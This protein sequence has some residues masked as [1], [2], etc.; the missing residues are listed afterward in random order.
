MDANTGNIV[1]IDVDNP[2]GSL[3]LVDANTGRLVLIDLSSPSGKL[4][5]V[6]ANTGDIVEIDYDN[7]TAIF[8][9]CDP[10]TG[11]IIEVDL[12]NPLGNLYSQ[13]FNTGR[14]ILESLSS[15]K[16]IG[17]E[18]ISISRQQ[19][20]FPSTPILDDFSRTN[21]SDI[22]GSLSWIAGPF[23]LD[24]LGINNNHCGIIGGGYKNNIWNISYIDTE[25]YVT[26]LDNA[27]GDNEMAIGARFNSDVGGY[28]LYWK[29]NG[30][31]QTIGIWRYDNSVPTQIGTNISVN[32]ASGNKIGLSV[33]G[34]TLKAYIYQNGIWSN[35]ATETDT[36][37]S[38]G[39]L[40]LY[41]R[42]DNTI[43]AYDDFGG[44]GTIDTTNYL[45]DSETQ[46][47]TD[48]ELIQ[49]I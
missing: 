28:F 17:S 46:F 48:S 13:D 3:Y 36:T 42:L 22:A 41:G 39:F 15:V 26:I 2:V 14:F 33:I 12:N 20:S 27:H 44:G 24:S 7:P 16:F 49:L 30:G 11:E 9:V 40:W 25:I 8:N 29:N 23:G 6:D 45:T 18:N 43:L 10:N 34:T 1:P 32:L 31:N 4:N 47:L 21:T 5:I 38:S 37:H 19:S 35:V